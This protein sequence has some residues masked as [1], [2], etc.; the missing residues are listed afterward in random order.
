[1]I[2]RQEIIKQHCIENLGRNLIN[3]RDYPEQRYFNES[4]NLNFTIPTGPWNHNS[5]PLPTECETGQLA[6]KM[7]KIDE[8][9]RPLH[10]WL[11][12]LARSVG[13]ISGKGAYWN[14]GPNYTVDPV[15]ITDE[16]DPHILLVKRNDN[17]NWAF[18]GGFLDY[19]A[20]S[21]L[22]ASR[23]ECAEETGVILASKPVKTIYIGP[24]AD[25][26]TTAHA[27]AFTN[28]KLWRLNHKQTL[29]PQTE[30]VSRVDWFPVDNLPNQL[31]GS[32]AKIIEFALQEL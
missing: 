21:T 6:S 8:L 11:K 31:H 3:Y 22:K 2:E 15:V 29:T 27:W 19:D 25:Q 32:H 13:V 5:E 28:A 7:C 23:R 10:P 16:T 1:M 20:E 4:D 26:R 9:G 18:P 14:W 30:E 24:V 17:G 12:E